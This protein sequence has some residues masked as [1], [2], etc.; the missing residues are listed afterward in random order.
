MMVLLGSV[1][2]GAPTALVA[3]LVIKDTAWRARLCRRVVVLV[4]VSA[5]AVAVIKQTD[6]LTPSMA[7]PI[8][9]AIEDFKQ[10]TGAYPDT[11]VALSPKYLPDLP[12]VRVAVIQPEVIYRVKEGLPYLAVPSALGDAFSKFEYN[13]GTMRWE[14]Y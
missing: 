4:A 11:L 8:A 12:A 3:L 5:M 14:H 6:K 1:L 13:F 9:K 7:A 10:E 2:L